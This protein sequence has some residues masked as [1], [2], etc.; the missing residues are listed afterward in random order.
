MSTITDTLP[1]SIVH[2]EEVCRDKAAL[3]DKSKVI[4]ASWYSSMFY[5]VSDTFKFLG[6]V[7][8]AAS[9]GIIGSDLK[10]VENFSAAMSAIQSSTVGLT[11]LAAATAVMGAGIATQFFASRVYHTTQFDQLEV[12]AQHTAKYLAQEIQKAPPQ[13]NVVQ[14]QGQFENP[15][16]ADGKTWQTFVDEQATGQTRSV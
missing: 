12:N 2:I 10:G 15:P 9:M 1:S 6:G 3:R 13:I 7:L 14:A 11:F 16:R 4:D 5:S 8:L